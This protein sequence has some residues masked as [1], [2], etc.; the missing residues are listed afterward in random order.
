MNYLLVTK[1]DG[2]LLPAYDSDQGKFNLIPDGDVIVCDLE[3]K[4]NLKHHRKYFSLLNFVFCHMT[5]EL[6]E[7]IFSVEMLRVEIAVRTGNVE[8]FYTFD[9]RRCLSANSISFANMG[10]KRFERVY[11]DTL[12]ICLKHYLPESNREEIELELINFM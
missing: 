10:Q 9:G 8:V 5:E 7:R 3:D 4:R 6:H 2:K 11:S 1:K 12:D